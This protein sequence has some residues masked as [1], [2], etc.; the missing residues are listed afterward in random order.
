VVWFGETLD[1]DDLER[2]FGALAICGAILVV[3]TSGLVHPAA[4]FP[5]VAKA[6]GATVIEVNPE[7]TAITAGAD[8]FIQAT[9]GAALPALV[10]AIREH[11]S[12]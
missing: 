9:A 10:D 6:A 7:E 3:G 1:P 4:G 11:R 12:A 8:L 2:A 5:G